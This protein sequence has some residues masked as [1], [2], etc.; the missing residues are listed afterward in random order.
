MPIDHVYSRLCS[1][2]SFRWAFGGDLCDEDADSRV[3][4]INWSDERDA[5]FTFAPVDRHFSAIC[6]IA[7]Y[8]QMCMV[9][10]NG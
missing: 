1:D 8:R 5:Q 7:K 9:R 3:C 2:D 6:F 10:Q 4:R